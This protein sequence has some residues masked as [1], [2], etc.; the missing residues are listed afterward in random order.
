MDVMK[1]RFA[2]H[3][4][5]I[6]M[7]E[8]GL[9][10]KTVANT[11]PTYPKEN[12]SKDVHTIFMQDAAPAHTAIKTQKWLLEYLLSIVEKGV[13]PNNPSDLHPIENLWSSIMQA[14]LDKRKPTT[15]LTQLGNYLESTYLQWDLPD[16]INSCIKL[17]G[18]YIG[19]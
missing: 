8:A 6:S 17:N 4:Q 12:V 16:R 9:T 15:N 1:P 18:E 13:W 2:V 19:K 3:E 14:E 10:Q 5:A 7:K 11:L